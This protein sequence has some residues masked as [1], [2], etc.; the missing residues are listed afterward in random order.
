M[1]I[2][3]LARDARV[4]DEASISIDERQQVKHLIFRYSMTNAQMSSTFLITI[5]KDS[6]L[7]E[8]CRGNDE[9]P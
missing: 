9:P 8:E 6:L 4:E 7:L 1:K 5:I 3:V 2:P